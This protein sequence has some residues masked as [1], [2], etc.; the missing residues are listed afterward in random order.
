MWFR[1]FNSFAHITLPL[2]IFRQIKKLFLPKTNTDL[3]EIIG[4][5]FASK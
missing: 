5:S 2:L 3:F 1:F 4:F